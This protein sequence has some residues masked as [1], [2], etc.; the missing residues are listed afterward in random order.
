LN[1]EKVNG[2]GGSRLL[3]LRGWKGCHVKARSYGENLC[4]KTRKW[5]IVARNYVKNSDF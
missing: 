2:S 4:E 3:S 5:M 1:A